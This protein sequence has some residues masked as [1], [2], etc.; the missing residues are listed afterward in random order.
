MGQ[1][2]YGTSDHV[3]FMASGDLLGE[4]D[5]VLLLV[6][7]NELLRALLG[8]RIDGAAGIRPLWVR[9]RIFAFFHNWYQARKESRRTFHE[10]ADGAAYRQRR[11]SWRAAALIDR[12][13]DLS[14]ALGG[15]RNNLEWMIRYARAHGVRPVFATQPAI[16]RADQSS[17]A[18]ATLWLGWVDG[19]GPKRLSPARL[20]QGLGLFNGELRAVCQEQGVEWIDLGAVDGVEEFYYDDCHFNDAGAQ[21]VAEILATWFATHD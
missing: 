16:W 3:R 20:A 4:V 13:P 15:Y 9:S 10:D 2:G 18:L 12:L 5:C 21:R 11:A 7:V 6:G 19:D 14:A 17:Q 1:S 8:N